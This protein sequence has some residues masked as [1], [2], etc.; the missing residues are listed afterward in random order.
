MG[1]CKIEIENIKLSNSSYGNKKEPYGHI[2]TEI[3]NKISKNNKNDEKISKNNDYEN[4]KNK[5]IKNN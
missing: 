5:V 1:H 3:E 4:I 2:N